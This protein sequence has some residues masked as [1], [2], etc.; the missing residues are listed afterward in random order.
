[1]AD[2]KKDILSN[3]P[4]DVL[5]E[6]VSGE[7]FDAKRFFGIAVPDVT[8]TAKEEVDTDGRGKRD[9]GSDGKRSD[10]NAVRS[11]FKPATSKEKA[12]EAKEG[13][14]SSGFGAGQQDESDKDKSGNDKPDKE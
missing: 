4:F 9:N 7:I 11:P 13:R 14:T 6:V 3:D 12:G 8:K 2:N 5:G 10:G 1:M